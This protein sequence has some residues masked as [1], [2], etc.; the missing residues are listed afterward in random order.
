MDAL[1]ADLVRLLTDEGLYRREAEA[2]VETWRDSWFENGTRLFYLLPQRAVDAI[3]PL[4]IE[5]KPA[6][7]ARVFVGRIEVITPQMETDAARA[8]RAGDLASLMKY[9]RVL[10][11]IAWRLLARP[12]L[13]LEASR[14]ESLLKQVA[15]THVPERPCG[16]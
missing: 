14:V 2:M 5:P 8:F 10:Q 12:S 11:P 16:G 9:G 13:Q 4:A 7:V 15:A 3:L 6:E 1:R